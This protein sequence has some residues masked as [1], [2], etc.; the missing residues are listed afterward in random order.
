MK[1]ERYGRML[2][3]PVFAWFMTIPFRMMC[4][5]GWGYSPG[6]PQLLKWLL[7]PARWVFI[8]LDVLRYHVFVMMRVVRLGRE[9]KA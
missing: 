8:D 6:V 4:R 5:P 7:S 1:S 9:R 2:V 3:S